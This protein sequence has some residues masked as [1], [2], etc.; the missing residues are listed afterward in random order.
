VTVVKLVPVVK[1]PEV[2][3]LLNLKPIDPATLLEVK[4]YYE[5]FVS[6]NR[7]SSA[8]VN[9]LFRRLNVSHPVEFERRIVAT[10][11]RQHVDEWLETGCRDDG[12]ESPEGRSLIKAPRA[13][14]VLQDYTSKQNPRLR[15]LRKPHEFVV[16]VGSSEDGPQTSAISG[17]VD[18]IKRAWRDVARLF[19][20]LITSDWGPRICKCRY[21]LCGLYFVHPKPR[22][23]Y[24]HGT[25]CGDH[26]MAWTATQHVKERRDQVRSELLDIAATELMKGRIHGPQWQDDRPRKI[27]LANAVSARIRNNGDAALRQVRLGVRLTWVTRNRQEIE[28]RRL[29]LDSKLS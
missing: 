29:E 27:Q 22:Q 28:K 11:L 21:S 13:L 4:R 1:P 24:K 5:D 10:K 26:Q 8:Q 3:A 25:F 12:G 7:G 20:G 16:E 2:V 23:W 6:S 9:R 18:P 19:F 15:F 14:E 17:F